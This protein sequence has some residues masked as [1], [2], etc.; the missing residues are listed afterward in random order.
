MRTNSREVVIYTYKAS[1]GSWTG[2]VVRSGGKQTVLERLTGRASKQDALEA[3]K[4]WA[5]LKKYTVV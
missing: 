1:N 5:A 2:E 3:A 4:N